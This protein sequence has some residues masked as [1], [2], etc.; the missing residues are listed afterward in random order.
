MFDPNHPLFDELLAVLR[1][2]GEIPWSIAPICGETALF[3]APLPFADEQQKAK[4]Y[5]MA[6]VILDYER[7]TGYAI[8]SEVW[9]ACDTEAAARDPARRPPSERE[10]RIE[11]VSVLLVKREDATIR[12]TADVREIVRGDDGK[13]VALRALDNDLA[14][15]QLGGTLTNLWEYPVPDA[16]R[17]VLW[18]AWGKDL[19]PLLMG[20]GHA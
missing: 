17:R 9:M 6:R 10:D 13:A 12:A 20:A 5:A 2:D 3:R 15:D 8:L 1:R 4:S 19:R 16:M 18:Q 11:A 7:A 14:F